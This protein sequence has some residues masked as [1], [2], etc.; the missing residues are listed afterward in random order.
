MEMIVLTI[1]LS[2]MNV[3]AND[4]DVRV[5]VVKNNLFYFLPLFIL[6]YL[7]F[8]TKLSVH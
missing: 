5:T 2:G 7:Q 8:Y 1:L 6:S 3:L 4:V